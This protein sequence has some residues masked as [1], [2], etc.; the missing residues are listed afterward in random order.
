MDAL[1]VRLDGITGVQELFLDSARV[2]SIPDGV[3]VTLDQ[4]GQA[5]DEIATTCRLSSTLPVVVTIIRSRVPNDAPNW[6]LLDP[7]YVAV[8]ARLMAD[9]KLGGLCDDIKS[10]G[11]E[12]SADLRACLVRCSYSVQY[13]TLEADATQL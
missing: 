5:S 7:F 3:V 6:Q 1:A 12:H 10:I 4:E 13:Q 11:R 2:A 9:R 8:H